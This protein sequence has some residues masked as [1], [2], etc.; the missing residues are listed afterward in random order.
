MTKIIVHLADGFEEMEAIIPIDVWRRAGFDVLTVSIS[1]ELKVTGAHHITLLADC[2]FDEAIYKDA[3]MIFLPG[4]IPGATNLD[5][6]RGL[7][8]QIHAFANQDKI[9]GAI[10]AAP[11]I[12]GHNHLLKGK[13]CTCFPGFES[14]LYEADYTAVSI[15]TDGNIVTGK[16]TGV[17]LEYALQIVARFTNLLVAKELAQKMQVASGFSF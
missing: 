2:L 10:C 4:G 14:E 9:L 15:Q 6:H 5:A 12:L 16:G 8:T 3:D 1:S 13:K 7:R 11:L 17:A